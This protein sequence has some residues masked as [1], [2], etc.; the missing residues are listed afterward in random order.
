[1]NVLLQIPVAIGV[2][3]ADAVS[4]RSCELFVHGRTRALRPTPDG[5]AFDVGGLVRTATIYA[6]GW[7]G[8]YST[9]RVGRDR[10]RRLLSVVP[11][12]ESR[13]R[14]SLR[15]AAGELSRVFV[16]PDGEA[17]TDCQDWRYVRLLHGTRAGASRR[18]HHSAVS[19]R[20]GRVGELDA[21]VPAVQLHEGA[22]DSRGV[23]VSAVR[24]EV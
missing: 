8:N 14:A 20:R 24:G 1:M 4:Q 9:R 19:W 18:A 13:P 5:W 15:R 21:R 12:V 2:M 16:R 10:A 22:Q 6:E 7:R 3:H 11:E 23:R 17:S